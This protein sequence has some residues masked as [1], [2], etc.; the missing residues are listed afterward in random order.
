MQ[1]NRRFSNVNY[2]L[3]SYRLPIQNR[4]PGYEIEHRN[5]VQVLFLAQK[6]ELKIK[7]A[8]RSD[9]RLT[10]TITNLKKTG[11]VAKSLYGQ[12]KIA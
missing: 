7:F 11:F 4:K 10:L 1:S 9:V 2:Y 6:A 8:R 3:F 5:A 12:I